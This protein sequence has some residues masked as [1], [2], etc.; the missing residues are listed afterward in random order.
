MITTLVRPPETLPQVA[1]LGFDDGWLLLP[2]TFLNLRV[3][4]VVVDHAYSGDP[5][6]FGLEL[7]G[8]CDPGAA[9]P[10]TNL[11]ISS[12]G[13]LLAIHRRST[14]EA[15][16]ST[17]LPHSC[18]WPLLTSYPEAVLIIGSTYELQSTW[19]ALWSMSIGR[20]EIIN[21]KECHGFG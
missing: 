9:L 1:R 14:I 2:P 6:T 12:Y 20:A 11:V 19:A 17:C 5:S 15:L 18:A 3:P 7:F 10:R 13:H 4:V 8:A 21:H 16:A